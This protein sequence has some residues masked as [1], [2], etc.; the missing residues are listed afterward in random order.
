MPKDARALMVIGDVV[1]AGV[2][3]A[4]ALDVREQ[5][6]GKFVLFAFAALV[7]L[8][9]GVAFARTAGTRSAS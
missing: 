1:I 5:S 3:L 6:S 8:F 7:L 2:M 9:R 4:F